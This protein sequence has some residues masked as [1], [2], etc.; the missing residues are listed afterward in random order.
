MQP[1]V[2]T[3][4]HTENTPLAWLSAL[5]RLALAWG[6]IFVLTFAEW[7][8]MAHQWWDIDTYNHIL[9][10]PVI[11][12]WLVSL[13]RDEL[14]RI[15][16]RGWWPGLAWLIAGLLLWF[17]GRETGLNIVAQAGAIAAF[18]GAML[19]VLGLRVGLILAFPLVFASFLVPFGD[20]LIPALQAVT[21]HIAV[22]LTHFSGVPAIVDGLFIDTPAGK[23]VVAEECSGVKFLV[24]MTALATLVGWTGFAR[25]HP[26]IVLLAGAA[27]V[28]VVANGVRAWGTI[29]AAQYVGIE[30]AGGIDHLI[31]GWVFFAVVIAAVLGA[32]W[33][34]FDRTPADAGLTAAEVAVHSLVRLERFSIGQGR[35]LAAIGA[36]AIVFAALARLG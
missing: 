2:A 11:V 17:G 27:L 24:A 14:A 7:R 6:A 4:P 22:S 25:W 8:E 33:R 21:A 20:E 9:L 36:L 32:A 10:V 1:E 23:F 18:Q 34:H 29:F 35:V 19:A 31:Y 28:S 30:R 26:R 16:P 12:G 15:T 3:I 13:R 5:V